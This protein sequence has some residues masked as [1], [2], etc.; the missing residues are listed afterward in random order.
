MPDLGSM[1]GEEVRKATLPKK[2]KAILD[3]HTDL[4]MAVR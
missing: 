2:S 4:L 3:P 1:G